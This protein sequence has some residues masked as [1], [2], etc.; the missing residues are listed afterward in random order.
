MIIVEGNFPK[1][2]YEYL[3]FPIKTIFLLVLPAENSLTAP[4]KLLCPIPS[5]PENRVP[6]T[7]KYW[8][9]A[10]KRHNILLSDFA[11]LIE[12]NDIKVQKALVQQDLGITFLLKLQSKR[13][14]PEDSFHRGLSIK[15]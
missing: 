10:W 1:K 12:T 13:T 11:G 2:D 6:A 5:L 14:R 9:S 4:W 7:G 3:L 15:T 8:N